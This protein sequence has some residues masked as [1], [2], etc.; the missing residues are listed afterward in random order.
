MRV[1][2]I[3]KE[4][5]GADAAALFYQ[6]G[7]DEHRYY[8]VGTDSPE[9][10]PA[11]RWREYVSLH[12]T[13][14]ELARFGPWRPPGLDSALPSWLSFRLYS[15]ET[16]GRFLFLG[17]AGGAWTDEEEARF[18][19]VSRTIA[20]IIR[21]RREREVGELRRR[22]TEEKLAANERRLRT[23]L[24]GS[25]DMIYTVDAEDR[26]T[27]INAAGI[28]LLGFSDKDT[29]IGKTFSDF[30]YNPG[31]REQLLRKVR[32]TGYAADYEIVLRKHDGST[33]FCLETAYAIRA[34]SGLIIE[35]QGIV[36]D[37][38]ERINSESAL[39]KTN[40]ELAD[41]N[42]RIQRAQ[43]LMIQHEK[44]ASIGQLAAGVAHEIN[45]PL[46]FLKS[47]HEMLEK[48]LK[49]IRAAWD[50]ARSCP[51]P[52]LE[53]IEGRRDLAYVF[54]D[55]EKMLEESSEGFARIVHIV[56]NL[57]SFSRSDQGA[58]FKPY[59]VNEGIETTLIVARNEIKYVAE[60][61]KAF[62]PLPKIRARG[63]E[64][65]QVLLNILVNAA[66]AIEAQ[67]R[68]ERGLIEIRTAALGDRVII[69]IRDDGPGIPEDIRMKIFD[70]FFT[71]KE[72]GK[73][74]GLGLS[75]SY[76]IVVSKHGGRLAVDSSPGQGTTFTIEL[77]IAGPPEA[78]ESHVDT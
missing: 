58:D 66:Q 68:S 10:I 76:D 71:T 52:N 21:V 9:T 26:V 4:S 51:S 38:T 73:G 75:I 43:N 29:I 39:W 61:R 12:S 72:P 33:V 8:L 37:I 65:N 30:A 27:G 62:G 31:D 15:T 22:E 18:V 74:T 35:L 59:D 78:S 44:L 16:E 34:P 48:Y 41:A 54:S 49:T 24:E 70:P 3:L 63:S 19:S 7:R 25:R 28:T 17:K 2:T 1:M 67:K 57:K 32:E 40:I 11:N 55:I 45:N 53:E 60:V 50:E 13:S 6:K 77:P 42:L 14:G 23:F 46:G 56:G 36:K 47:N 64:I 69:G 20:P 5:L